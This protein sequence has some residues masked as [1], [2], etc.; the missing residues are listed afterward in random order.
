MTWRRSCDGGTLDAD[1]LQSTGLPPDKYYP[2]TA[3]DGSCSDAAPGWKKDASHIR[4]WASVKP[5]LASIK[6]ALKKYGPL[7][8]TMMVYADLMH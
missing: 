1:F 6:S 5:R 3:T 7:P 8:T 2:Y 4:T